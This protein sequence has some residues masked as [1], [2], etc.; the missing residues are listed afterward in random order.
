MKRAAL[1][2]SLGL[3]CQPVCAQAAPDDVRILAPTSSWTLDFA[4]ERC[5]LIRKFGRKF[6]AA[7]S[8]NLYRER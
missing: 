4:D 1:V 6:Q 7:A 2:V 5:S 8:L 3:L